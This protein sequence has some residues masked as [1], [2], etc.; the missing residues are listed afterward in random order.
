MV[1]FQTAFNIVLG[2]FSALV[3]WLLNTLYQSMRELT[4]ADAALTGK[5]NQIEVLVAGTY[6]KRAEFESKVDAMFHKLDSIEEKI[7]RR[8][9]GYGRGRNE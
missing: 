8:L 4:Q 6:V 2:A 9:E 7:D 5:V 3:G 1:D